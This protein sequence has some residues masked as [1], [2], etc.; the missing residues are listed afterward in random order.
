M[1]RFVLICLVIAALAAGTF[2]ALRP[3]GGPEPLRLGYVSTLSGRF[4]ARSMVGRDGA[5]LAVEHIN[6][7]GGV[8]GRP[9][10]LC[11]VDDAFDPELARKAMFDLHEQGVYAIVGP[12]VSAMAKP[13]APLAKELGMLLVS[14]TVSSDEFSDD[15]G[16]FLRIMPSARDFSGELGRYCAAKL[17]LNTFTAVSDLANAP[18]VRSYEQ[19]LREGFLTSGGQSFST[20]EY[21]SRQ[22]PVYEDLAARTLSTRPDGV[23][24]V[25]DPLDSAMLCQHIRLLNG[26]E[27]LFSS[28]WGMS[29]ELIQNGGKAVDGLQAI[30]PYNPESKNPAF[31]EFKKAF[32]ARF[33]LE[34]D[35]TSLFTYETV[36]LLARGLT[37]DPKA[38]GRRLKSIILSQNPQHGLQSDYTLDQSG[39]V[40]R[41]LFLLTV[42]DGRMAVLD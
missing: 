13:M 28:P 17:R 24:M 26:S 3:L 19:G 37:S 29:G 33:G 40:K 25:A 2:L 14:P 1:K 8:A 30:V 21:D 9:L 5:V 32:T 11:V 36:M 16:L 15:G 35:F 7:S 27:P 10:M 41:P 39:G 38:T 23:C 20:I 22:S 6:A 12:F 18:Y 4:S 42:K 31:V 34:P